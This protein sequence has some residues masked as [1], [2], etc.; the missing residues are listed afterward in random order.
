M[1]QYFKGSAADV[2]MLVQL[3]CKEG[4]SLSDSVE[5]HADLDLCCCQS[6]DGRFSCD[7]AQIV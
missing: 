7:V 6:F 5:T 2:L 3:D 1:S 4:R